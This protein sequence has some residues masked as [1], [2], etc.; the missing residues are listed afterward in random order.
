MSDKLSPS[1]SSPVFC[2]ADTTVH[3]SK[4]SIFFRKENCF[5]A[6]LGCASSLSKDAKFRFKSSVK[7][8]RERKT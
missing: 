7:E 3:T 8:K 6:I 1:K 5:G 4:A 2:S